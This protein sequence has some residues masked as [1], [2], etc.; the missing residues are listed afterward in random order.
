[1]TPPGDPY[2]VLG[3]APGASADEVRRAYRRLA[4]RYHPDSAGAAASGWFLV[5]Q[6]AYEAIVRAPAHDA[7]IRRR[8][9]GAPGPAGP[10]PPTGRPA[11]PGPSRTGSGSAGPAA[12]PR[13]PGARPGA[14]GEE[15]GR[16][17]QPPPDPAH[18]DDGVRGRRG[19]RTARPGSTSYDEAEREAVEPRWQ[20]ATWYGPSSGT[21]WTINPREF[22]DPRKHGP[23][24][25]AR[26]RP[27]ASRP[28][29]GPDPATVT[30]PDGADSP[31][32][33]DAAEAKPAD[34]SATT[35]GAA[36]W[37]PVRR[38]ARD[39]RPPGRGLLD[40]LAAAADAILGRVRPACAARGPR[41]SDPR[42]RSDGR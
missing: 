39:G 26:G 5:V 24:Y 30:P 31:P 22:A 17:T 6:A 23:E 32:R 1:M 42:P 38:A 2:R 3:V 16:A 28:S 8:S 33:H 27:A 14:R 13:R 37:E 25:L 7:T 35:A 19:A 11:G 29:L 10:G 40:R 12:R 20:G 36:T 15:A 34:V 41:R 4:K 21:Y 18:R 9:S